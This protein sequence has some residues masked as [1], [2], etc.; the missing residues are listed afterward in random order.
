MHIPA[1]RWLASLGRERSFLVSAVT[2]VCAL[3]GVLSV[4]SVAL[5]DHGNR[6][7]CGMPGCSEIKLIDEHSARAR[8][9]HFGRQLGRLTVEI[10]VG[11]R[12]CSRATV[13]TIRAYVVRRPGRAVI[14]TRVHAP[15]HSPDSPCMRLLG[16]RNIRVRL[17]VPV[18]RLKLFDG[19]F[20]PPKLRWPK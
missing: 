14:T 13:P 8:P 10:S 6:S 1:S 4:S 20:S 16:V 19:S 7:S 3:L 9:W 5:A 18:S 17:D 2:A 15:P 11:W 12:A